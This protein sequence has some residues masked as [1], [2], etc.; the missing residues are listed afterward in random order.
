MNRLFSLILLTLLLCGCAVQQNAEP[1]TP[2]GAA[3]KPAAEP[4]EPA[5]IYV[6]NSE[7]EVQTG[8]AV[9]C[10]L[11]D[12]S[13]AYGIRTAGEDL[14]IFSGTEST[15]LTRCTGEGPYCSSIS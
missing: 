6:P 15:T 2:S 14:L 9:R 7:L 1:T 11:P 12:V 5:G 13:D 10:Y 3:T 8:G 4:T